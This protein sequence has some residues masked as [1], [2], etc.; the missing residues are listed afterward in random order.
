MYGTKKAEHLRGKH[1]HG[2]LV[3][4]AGVCSKADQCVFIFSEH[5]VAVRVEVH[6][7]DILVGGPNED[8]VKD[9]KRRIAQHLEVRDLGQVKS[10]L[11]MQVPW[12]RKAST[13]AL[14]N[15]RHSADLLKE[16]NME[17]SKSNYTPMAKGMELGG[18]KRLPD[19]N[20][21]A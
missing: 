15:P 5:G 21:Y 11:G 18:G 8:A 14:S 13:V 12:D 17:G 2:K 16:F 10:Y 7:D 4:E 9:V 3:E 19:G 1:L 20:R 6:V